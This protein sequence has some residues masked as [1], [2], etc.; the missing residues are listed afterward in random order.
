MLAATTPLAAKSI[1]FFP[2]AWSKEKDK[3]F[4]AGLDDNLK[5]LYSKIKNADAAGIED[6]PSDLGKTAKKCAG[7]V[8]CLERAAKDQSDYDFS[9]LLS[10]VR[11]RVEVTIFNKKGRK[12]GEGNVDVEEDA[13]PEDVA[14]AVLG[15]V[16]RLLAKIGDETEQSRGEDEF[17]GGGESASKAKEAVPAKKLSAS[18]KKEVMR[19]GF[20]AYQGGDYTRAAESFR[21]ADETELADTAIEIKKLLTKAREAIQS[22]DWAAALDNLDRAAEQ[23]EKIRA[24]GYKA[25]VYTLSLIHI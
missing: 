17:A 13:D 2:T 6:A 22:E 10:Y 12:V 3:E 5:M 19:T 4:A 20:K 18:E 25:I 24:A 14:G 15:T 23:D 9:L 21:Q 1:L 11:G 7:K 8:A 16:N